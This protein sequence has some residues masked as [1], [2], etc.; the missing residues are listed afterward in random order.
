MKKYFFA[1]SA[2]AIAS[3]SAQTPAADSDPAATPAAVSEQAETPAVDSEQT[4]T[5]AVDFEQVATPAID[6]EQAETPAAV[7]DQAATPAVASYKWSGIYAGGQ[8][9]G[10]WGRVRAKNKTDKVSVSGEETL[11]GFIGGLYA[12]YNFDL[13][14]KVILGVESDFVWGDIDKKY[15]GFEIKQKWQG[16]TRIRAGYIFERFLP[17]LAVGVAYSEYSASSLNSKIFTGWTIG[18]GVDY[19]LTDHVLLRV[20]YRYNDFGSRTVS[21][22]K[23]SAKSNDVRL[24]VAYKL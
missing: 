9:G 12:G 13:G 10:V 19:A 20:E 7:S 11:D 22:T 24:G 21:D 6:S 2:F 17:Y 23:I 14:K 15:T 16:A 3:A 18:T 5:P 4:A 1:V 8:F